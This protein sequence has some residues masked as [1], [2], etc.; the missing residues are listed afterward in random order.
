MADHLTRAGIKVVL[1]GGAAVS[2]YTQSEYVSRDIDLVNL[3][4]SR[5]S[6]LR[7]HMAEIGFVYEG[8]HF[9]H[10]D[11]PYFIEFPP[12]PL[13]IGEE[14]DVNVLVKTFSTGSLPVISPTD[15]VKDRLAAYY[16]WGDRQCLNQAVLIWKHQKINEAEVRRWSDQEGKLSE[17]TKIKSNFEC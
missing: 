1:S 14:L 6:R 5:V 10:H 11:S 3:Y 7:A 9:K 8:K 17:Y 16:H 4:P 13:S 2:L 15:C 12:G